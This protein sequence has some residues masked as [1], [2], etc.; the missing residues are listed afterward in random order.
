MIDNESRQNL[1]K[2]RIEQ[3]HITSLEASV[4]IENELLRGAVNRIYYSMFY[5]LQALSL[6]YRFETSKHAQLIGWFNKTFINP[7]LIEVRFSKIVTKAYN[8]RTKGD[9]AS[10]YLPDKEEIELMFAEMKDFIKRI[11][12]FIEEPEH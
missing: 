4:L 11:E 7:G 8:L 6:K 1:V 10:I 3:A 9:Y 2:Y 5:M 12:V